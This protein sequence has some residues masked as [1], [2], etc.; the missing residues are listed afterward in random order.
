MAYIKTVAPDQ[1]TGSLERQYKA[2]I[3]RSGRVFNVVQAQSLNP[4]VME[5]SLRLYI[6]AMQAPSSLSRA[7]REMIAVVVSRTNECFY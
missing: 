6:A 7:E 2:A 5:A 3:K 1:A 4:G